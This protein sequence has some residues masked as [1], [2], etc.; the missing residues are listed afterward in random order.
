MKAAWLIALITIMHH[1]NVQNVQISKI[2]GFILRWWYL[3]VFQMRMFLSLTGEQEFWLGP[4]GP[5]L[6]PIERNK[7]ISPFSRVLSVW[8][9]RAAAWMLEETWAG[10][11][12]SALPPG[13]C[14]SFLWTCV[15][16]ICQGWAVQRWWVGEPE[17][18]HEYLKPG[19]TL[20]PSFSRKPKQIF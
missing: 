7:K 8:T 5:S 12:T 14:T 3:C 11:C 16:E 4:Y 9:H 17:H 13:Q 19:L 1:Q 2:W 20:A 15:A 18:N 6:T 10:L